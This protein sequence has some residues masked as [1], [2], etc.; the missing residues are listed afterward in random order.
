MA[1]DGAR[2]DAE[3]FWGC[4]SVVRWYQADLR[5]GVGNVVKLKCLE[6]ESL[7]GFV[8]NCGGVRVYKTLMK[9]CVRSGWRLQFSSIGL[10][11]SEV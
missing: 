9:D 3:C 4:E 11:N 10:W 7:W 8:K 1:T 2:R 5:Q 6:S